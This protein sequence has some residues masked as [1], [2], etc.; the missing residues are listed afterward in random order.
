LL[1]IFELF[2]FHILHTSV[3]STTTNVLQATQE[4]L[5]DSIS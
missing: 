2:N 5:S 4:R 1:T 3:L